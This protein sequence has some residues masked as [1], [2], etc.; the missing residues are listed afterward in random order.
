MHAIVISG[1]TMGLGV[2]RS[3]GVKGI[4]IVLFHHDE[5][6]MA[7]KSR[8]VT[9]SIRTVSPEHDEQGFIEE[10][11]TYGAREGGGILMPTS[12]ESVVALAHHQENLAEYFT[13]ACPDWSVV[14]RFVE[15]KH[16]YAL[17]SELG[18]PV[19]RT[20][21]PTSREEAREFARQLDMPCLVKPSQSHLFYTHFKSK[22][23]PVDSVDK[24]MEVYN[25]AAKA[26]LE[27]MLQEF[28]P[29]DDCQGVNYNSYFWEG[30]CI[31]EF[32]ARKVR[33]APPTYGSPRV[34][35][36]EQVPEIIEP[37]RKI[38]EAVGYSGF[39]C[40]EFKKDTRDGIYKLMEVNVRH[41]L[42]SMLAVSCGINFPWIEYQH[43]VHGVLPTQADFEVNKY[44]ID[45]TRDLG[46]SVKFFRQE[47]FSFRDYVRPY[48]GRHVFAILDWKD[49]KPFLRRCTRLLEQGI[50]SVLSSDG[51]HTTS[52]KDAP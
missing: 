36:S 46:Y 27:V 41:N 51:D 42:S 45:I 23:F 24:L 16:T 7:H 20:F 28:I 5:R 4:P 13:V 18:I 19:P 6:D 11:L 33:N 21:C 10:L 52:N 30:R 48:I 3:L 35:I 26:G 14:K 12:D 34:A 1:H 15:K 22:M 39:A 25:N 9:R 37:G 40:T 38:L 47:R 8:Y 43:R 31:V 29:G 49:P 2:V 50:H 44:W 32:T 17:A